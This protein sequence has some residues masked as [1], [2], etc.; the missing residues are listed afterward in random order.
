M[1]DLRLPIA[2]LK[3]HL[4]CSRYRDAN[5]VPTSPLTDYLSTAKER[6]VVSW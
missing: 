5:P 4:S 1:V 2:P 3:T 6:D